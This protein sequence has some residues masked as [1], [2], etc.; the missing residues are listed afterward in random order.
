MRQRGLKIP[1]SSPVIKKG[2]VLLTFPDAIA[3]VTNGR[4]I[5]RLEWESNEEY[6][7]LKDEKLTIHTKGQDHIW[8]VSKGDLVNSDWLVLPQVN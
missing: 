4:K 1:M 3:E 6:G 7:Y 2:P 5:T 8:L